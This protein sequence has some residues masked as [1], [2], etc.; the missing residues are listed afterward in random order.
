MNKVSIYNHKGGVSKTTTDFFKRP[1]ARAN[2]NLEDIDRIP[3][4][5]P[6]LSLNDTK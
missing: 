1:V 5:I 2:I 6:P 3:V 4:L